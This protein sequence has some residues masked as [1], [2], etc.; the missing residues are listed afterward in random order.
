MIISPQSWKCLRLIL[1]GLLPTSCAL[2]ILSLWDTHRIE[3]VECRLHPN[4]CHLHLFA[5][6]LLGLRLFT[7]PEPGAQSLSALHTVDI[8][9][10]LLDVCSFHSL[11]QQVWYSSLLVSHKTWECQTFID[12]LRI[13]RCSWSVKDDKKLKT[14]SIAL[15]LNSGESRGLHMLRY[16]TKSLKS[17]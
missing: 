10:I 7:R 1:T 17:L 9:L 3:C 13:D 4:G 6:R 5:V 2:L 11:F 14:R 12:F 15:R 16:G 8:L